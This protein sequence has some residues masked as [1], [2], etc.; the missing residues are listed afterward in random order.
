MHALPSHRKLRDQRPC[1]PQPDALHRALWP[2]HPRAGALPDD[3]GCDRFRPPSLQSS[4]TRVPGELAKRRRRPGDAGAWRLATGAREL[5][6]DYGCNRGRGAGSPPV[7]TGDQVDR[8]S[9]PRCGLDEIRL[10]PGEGQSYEQS[11]PRISGHGRSDTRGDP[12]VPRNSHRRSSCPTSRD[13]PSSGLRNPLWPLRPLWND[14]HTPTGEGC[15]R[16][17]PKK[18]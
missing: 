15:Y 8:R 9:W 18:H 14:N 3:H 13:G 17:V 10:E 16:Y 6:T 1:R 11:N 7:E 4:A 2:P 12:S 5:S